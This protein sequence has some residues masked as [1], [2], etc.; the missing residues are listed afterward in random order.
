MQELVLKSEGINKWFGGVH[1]LVDMGFE[2]R[3]GEVHALVGE[4]GA[5]KS[6]YI[7]ILSGVHLKD[8]GATRFD[9]KPISFRSALEAR[10]AGI[11]MVPQ[12]IELAPKLTVAEN[13]YMG[14]YP[15]ARMGIVSWKDLFRKAREDGGALRHGGHDAPARWRSWARGTGSSSRSSRP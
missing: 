10:R 14:V 11:G 15:S 3:Q 12:I 6:T 2:L 8:S 7:K 13:I 1:A 5:G 4:N 9:G